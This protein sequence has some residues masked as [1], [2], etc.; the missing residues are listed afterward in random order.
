M[1][2]SHN[3]LRLAGDNYICYICYCW[4]V[5]WYDL[6]HWGEFCT[7]LSVVNYLL[8]KHYDSSAIIPIL[9]IH[10]V[11][12]LLML[13][14]FFRLTH[15]TY[16]DPPVLPLGHI[17]LQ[18][19]QLS[20]DGRTKH[21]AKDGISGIEYKTD[22]GSGGTS[23][24]GTSEEDFPDS[25]GLEMFYTKDVF[26][27]Q[28]DGKP[29]FCS[30]C[31]SWKL[32]RTHHCSMNNRCILKMDHFCPWIGGPLGESNIKYFIQFN[33]YAALYC[34]QLVVVMAIYLKKQ[35]S[36]VCIGRIPLPASSIKILV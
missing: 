14:S 33:G 2:R 26:V 5:I 34:T 7:D 1:D 8:A 32:D 13:S 24:E 31:A 15:I 16:F 28:L 21:S 27:C 18:E 20:K 22:V 23:T 6:L 9:V 17:A 12:L 25:A 30:E 4:P 19:R 35:R 11:L 29:K 10:F 3:T 36:E